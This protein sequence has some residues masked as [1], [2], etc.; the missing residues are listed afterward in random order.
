MQPAIHDPYSVATPRQL[1][2]AV[3]RRARLQRL[4]SFPALVGEM[5]PP[6][7]TQRAPAKEKPAET[8]AQRQKRIHA[9]G[10]EPWFSIV[11]E[12]DPTE[13]ARPRIE[14]VIQATARH[15]GVSRADIL[16]ARRTAAIVRP[17]QVACYL[18]KVL[19]LRSLPEI[20]RRMGHRDHTTILSSVRKITRLIEQEP[21]LAETVGFLA[22]EILDAHR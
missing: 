4:Q 7:K 3:A 21:N 11:C 2:E 9:E 15:Y 12:I 6:D 5:M 13:P 22:R 19:T 14:E 16:S 1:S 10:K 20:G 17:R 18:A 8:W